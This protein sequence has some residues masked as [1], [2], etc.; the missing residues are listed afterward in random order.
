[1]G[2]NLKYSY[3]I[4]SKIDNFI[5]FQPFQHTIIFLIHSSIDAESFTQKYTFVTKRQDIKGNDY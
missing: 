1:M 3:Q 4:D 2:G 5:L